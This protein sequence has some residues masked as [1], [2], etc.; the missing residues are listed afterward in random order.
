MAIKGSLLDQA[1]QQ[2]L[3]RPGAFNP[4]LQG[5]FNPALVNIVGGIF[6]PRGA[7]AADLAPRLQQYNPPGFDPSQPV[8][9]ADVLKTAKDVFGT[10]ASASTTGLDAGSPAER[11]YQ[12][13]KARVAQLTA[14]NPELQRYEK[15]R[16]AAVASGATPAQVQSAEDIG[17]QIWKEKYSGTPMA[18]SGGAVGI[19]NPLMQRTFGY[20]T[21]GAPDQQ[22][23]ELTTGPTPAVPQVDQ[24]LNPASPTFIGGEGAPLL[25]FTREDLTP[26]LLEK[27]QQE[28]LKRAK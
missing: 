22:V 28:L 24:A 3:S 9:T 26:E 4:S 27:Y 16:Q 7:K 14:Q 21:G 8:T 23:G 20:Q 25:D 6:K 5:I 10:S 2:R 12:A 13:E 19:N 17:M 18:Q 15:A 11:A 1:I